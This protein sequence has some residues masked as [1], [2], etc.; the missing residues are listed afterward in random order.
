MDVISFVD[1][2]GYPIFA[3]SPFRHQARF[4]A[5]EYVRYR[6]EGGFD[7]YEL[8]QCY[9]AVENGECVSGECEE[10]LRQSLPLPRYYQALTDFTPDTQDVNEL[11]D[12][13]MMVEVSQS[14]F[15]CKLHT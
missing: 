2:G 9:L 13:G 12:K 6:P 3:D 8:E 7:A 14:Y 1:C 4:R 5:G 15:D 10:L 11:V